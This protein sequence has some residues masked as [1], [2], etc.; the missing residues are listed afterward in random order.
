MAAGPGF[1]SGS[2]M[3]GAGAIIRVPG[4]KA[5]DDFGAPWLRCPRSRGGGAGPGAAGRGLKLKE[6][7]IGGNSY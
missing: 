3:M 4:K 7:E 6:D 2:A 1:G 5:G